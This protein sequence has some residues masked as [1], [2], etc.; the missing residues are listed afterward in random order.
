MSAVGFEPTRSCLQWILRPPP[1]PLG[2]TD[3]CAMAAVARHAPTAGCQVHLGR[4]AE[5]VRVHGAGG[6]WGR[7]WAWHGQAA[8]P[9]F[10][11]ACLGDLLSAVGF[12]PTRSCLQWI[13]SPP[14]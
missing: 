1:W 4:G 8:W 7:G 12:G 14:P 10:S 5:H 6:G 2:Q 13:L 11:R 3:G 9:G